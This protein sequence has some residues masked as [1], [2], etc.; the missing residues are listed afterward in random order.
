MA[1]DTLSLIRQVS[2][3]LLQ[4]H[5]SALGIDMQVGRLRPGIRELAGALPTLAARPR[6]RGVR[7]ARARRSAKPAYRRRSPVTWPPAPHCSARPTSSSSPRQHRIS[8]AAAAR[9]YFGI[10]AE[11][12]LD[13]L[14]S[15][16]EELDIQGHWQ[17]VA[18]GSLREAM[19]D[20]HRELTQ[21]V[22]AETRERDPARAVEA[23]REQQAAAAAHARGIVEDIRAQPA[24]ADFASLSVALAGAAPAR[25]RAAVTR[26][27]LVVTTHERPDALA[28]VL[29]SV[30]CQRASAGRADRRRRRLGSRDGGRRRSSRGGSG[31][32]RCGTPGSP[33]RASGPAASAMSRSR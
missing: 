18:R 8:V 4:R 12:G 32:I 9:T 10:G 24:V 25:R 30:A 14:R 33:T 7:R 19:Y 23:W 13:W 5:R 27:C 1:Q 31:S 28:R 20:A 22:L 16:I 3:W 26:C 11:F 2:Y 29:A 21:R 6:A 15:R 17:A